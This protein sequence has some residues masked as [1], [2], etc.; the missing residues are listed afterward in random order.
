MRNK[1]VFLGDDKLYISQRI[2]SLK[3]H[4]GINGLSTTLSTKFEGGLNLIYE[5]D[6]DA[7]TWQESIA[8]AA[9]SVVRA[10]C[11]GDDKSQLERGKFDPHPKTP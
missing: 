9:L 6:D 11:K 7:V 8:T 4:L 10:C 1:D 5:V 3:L 2:A